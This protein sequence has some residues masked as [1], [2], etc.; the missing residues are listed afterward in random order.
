MH[1]FT[2]MP[3]DVVNAYRQGAPDA[4]G[5]PPERHVSSGDG[6]PCHHCLKNIPQGAPMLILAYK[7]FEGTHP[8]AEVGPIFLCAN[9]CPCGDSTNLPDILM[10]SPNYLLKG[11]SADDRIVYGTADTIAQQQI[12]ARLDAVFANPEVAYIHARS[13][14]NN[15]YQLR[16]DRG[17]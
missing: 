8:Y 17:D 11:Y 6:T 1:R 2:A 9:S 7:P 3:T 10:T 16:I 15:C 12:N 14:R 13:A 5:T 4:H